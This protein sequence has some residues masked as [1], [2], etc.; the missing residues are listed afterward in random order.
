MIS[1]FPEMCFANCYPNGLNIFSPAIIERVQK[2]GTPCFRP[3]I[4]KDMAEHPL[5][6][7]MMKQSWDQDPALRPKFSEC[8]K[9]LK[10]MNKGK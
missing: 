2:G 4:T 1:S 6:I 8:I 9:L 10:Q 3:R 7:Q 5:F